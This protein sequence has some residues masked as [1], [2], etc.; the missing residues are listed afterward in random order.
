MKKKFLL[1]SL[2]MILSL[3]LVGC[4][5]DKDKDKNDDEN[6]TQ[7]T[8]EA[9]A[10]KF[11]EDYES[12]N[13]KETS[14][15]TINRSVEI[16]EDNPFVYV[17]AAELVEKIEND[18]SFY[19][20]FGS[21]KCPW[22]RS[23]IEKAIEMAEENEIKIVYYVDIW[24]EDGNE[25]L[26]DKYVIN[27]KGKLEQTI[28]G[29][30]EYYRLLELLDEVLDDYV[31][32]NKKGKKFDTK[33]KRIFAPNFIYVSG[34]DAKVMVTGVSEKQKNASD[35]LTDEILEDQGGVFNEF[36]AT[37]VSCGETLC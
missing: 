36:F 19:V 10:A 9:D 32:E 16:D 25:I 4:G 5:D 14:Y 33:E 23:V 28:K 24:D 8:Q 18:E 21:N 22:C 30:D 6:K 3:L 11:K 1:F 15:G 29:T 26:R 7:E 27:D 31:L 37:H 12:L 2:L 35:E 34:G 17:T 13:G 20:Y